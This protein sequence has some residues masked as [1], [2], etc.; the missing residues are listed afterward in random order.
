MGHLVKHAELPY[1]YSKVEV[2]QYTNEIFVKIA[3][4]GIPIKF[5]ELH[6]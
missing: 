2:M 4:S 6:S 5:D 1:V 3:I